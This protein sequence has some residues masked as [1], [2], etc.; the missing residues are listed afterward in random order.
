MLVYLVGV[1]ITQGGV[2][3]FRWEEFVLFVVIHIHIVLRS[4]YHNP[5]WQYICRDYK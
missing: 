1:V 3:C 4:S 2:F 5:S